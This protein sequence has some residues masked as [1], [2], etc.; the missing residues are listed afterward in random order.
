M[1]INIKLKDIKWHEGT[2]LTS[3]DVK[4]TVDLIK[5]NIDSPYNALVE[6]I[7]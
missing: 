1:S 5:Q 2:T 3:S 6:N 4:F 7:S